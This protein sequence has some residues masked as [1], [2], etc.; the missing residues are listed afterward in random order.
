MQEHVRCEALEKRLE[1]AN[2][3]SAGHKIK[4][5][6]KASGAQNCRSFACNLWKLER[7]SIRMYYFHSFP[8]TCR[9]MSDVKRSRKGLKA[10]T[11]SLLVT[12]ARM[13]P[14]LLGPRIAGHLRAI[15][16]SW[17]DFPIL[18]CTIFTPFPLYAGTCQMWSAREKA[19]KRQP[20]VCWSQKQG[21]TQSFSGPELQ[22]ICAQF[23]KVGKT[24]PF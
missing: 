21:W 15:C 20:L 13:D 4:D 22:V 5:G 1:S 11:S 6:P 9:N 18:E 12:K 14:K 2:L 24:F 3:W 23:V 8:L 17:K 16:E 19:W 7:L 10:P